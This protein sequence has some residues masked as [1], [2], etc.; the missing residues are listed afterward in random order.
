MNTK[1]KM[2]KTIHAA[3]YCLYITK[4]YTITKNTAT[5]APNHDRT[6]VNT[7]ITKNTMN[8]IKDPCLLKLGAISHSCRF[9]IGRK[10]YFFIS[11]LHHYQNGKNNRYYQMVFHFYHILY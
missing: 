7:K 3:T 5:I 10:I 6:T 9:L 4:K 8:R 11:I 1:M 2:P